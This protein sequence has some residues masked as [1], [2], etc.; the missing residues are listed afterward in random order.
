M[1]SRSERLGNGRAVGLGEQAPEVAFQLSW[2]EGFW[3]RRVRCRIGPTRT[4]HRRLPAR[5]RRSVGLFALFANGGEQGQREAAPD[6]A[7]DQNHGHHCRCAH[8]GFLPRS[9]LLDLGLDA[10][11]VDDG[12]VVPADRLDDR[13]G[14]NLSS[15]SCTLTEKVKSPGVEPTRTTRCTPGWTCEWKRRW[16]PRAENPSMPCPET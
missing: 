14:R 13:D 16:P 3:H 1:E 10:G 11:E 9:L 5:V 15:T 12:Q 7:D 2:N 6:E 4:R 8:S